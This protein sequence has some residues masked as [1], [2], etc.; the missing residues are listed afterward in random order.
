MRGVDYV[1]HTRS[2]NFTAPLLQKLGY[3]KKFNPPKNVHKLQGV[4]FSL[5][6]RIAPEI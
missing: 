1:T 5:G 4:L 3:A 6:A 2:L